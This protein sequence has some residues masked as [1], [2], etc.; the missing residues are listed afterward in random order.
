LTSESYPVAQEVSSEGDDREERTMTRML[1]WCGLAVVAGW[2]LLPASLE[3]LSE[4][5][6]GLAAE[7]SMSPL[8]PGGV[9]KLA[10]GVALLVAVWRW[11]T[12]KSVRGKSPRRKR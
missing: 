1:F 12:P 3:S 9:L 7:S 4:A 10:G 5:L 8:P 2:F 6:G 11:A